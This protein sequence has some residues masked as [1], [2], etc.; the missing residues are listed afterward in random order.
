MTALNATMTTREVATR[1]NELAQQERWFEIQDEFFS[2]DVKSIEPANS[3]YMKSAQ[4]KKAVRH[5]AEQFVANIEAAHKLYTSE[6]FV[7]GNHFAVIREKE[8]TVKGLGRIQINQIMMYEVRN[9]Q[10]ISEQF[11]Y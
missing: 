3:P 5:K 2:D 6:P 7:T 10:I 9:G 1:F 4:G 8:M 11:F